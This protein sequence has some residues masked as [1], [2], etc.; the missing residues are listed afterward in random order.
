MSTPRPLQDDRRRSQ[1]T[2]PGFVAAGGFL[3]VVVLLFAVVL[4][5]GM[6]GEDSAG[7]ASPS[8]APGSRPDD[9]GAEN[10]E[11]G[12]PEPAESSEV[13]TE[14][15]PATWELYR[16]VA[17]PVSKEAGPAVVDGDLARC[18]A[19]SPTGAVMAAAQIGHRVAL[20]EDWRAVVDEQTYGNAKG[21]MV[22]AREKAA[23]SA[24]PPAPQPGELGQIAGF[25]VITYTGDMA[26]IQLVT[27]FTGG[28]LQVSTSTLRWTEGDWRYEISDTGAPQKTLTTLDGYT[29]WGGV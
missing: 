18:Y 8:G 29:E 9:K 10:G 20:A 28:T 16:T 6:D 15:P 4:V 14:P 1:W 21:A 17:L 5:A 2:R 3:S 23:E 22:T 7:P 25:D 24:S 19:R 26:V 13:P 27:R 12:C 11:N